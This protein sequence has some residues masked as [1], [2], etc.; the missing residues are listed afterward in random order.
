[1]NELL[2]TVL[3][4]QQCSP[5]EN[6]MWQGIV[7]MAY[8]CFVGSFVSDTA[9]D[10]GMGKW[11]WY[12]SY[13]PSRISLRA[14]SG[15]HGIHGICIAEFLFFRWSITGIRGSIKSLLASLLAGLQKPN[16]QNRHR[17]TKGNL[18]RCHFYCTHLFLTSVTPFPK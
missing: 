10:D 17:T 5:S 4:H 18:H 7:A 14:S 13:L 9:G 15:R 16:S 3:G 1:M 6:S 12:A 2:V 8:A 11:C